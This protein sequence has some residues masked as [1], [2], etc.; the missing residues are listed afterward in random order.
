M[1]FFVLAVLGVLA[2]RAYERQREESQRLTQP[3]SHDDVWHTHPHDG[4]HY[5]PH[6]DDRF[7]YIERERH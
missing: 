2:R 6:G 1:E 3:H 4:F 5:H 7:V